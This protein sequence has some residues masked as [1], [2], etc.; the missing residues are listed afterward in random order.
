MIGYRVRR[1][2]EAWRAEDRATKLFLLWNGANTVVAFAL[3]FG[4]FGILVATREPGFQRAILV[5]YVAVAVVW[6]VSIFA[7]APAYDRVVPPEE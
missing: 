6:L 2:L 7:I 4:A 3:L 1:F 5:G